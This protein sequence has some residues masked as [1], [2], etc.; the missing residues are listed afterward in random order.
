MGYLLIKFI[1][2]YQGMSVETVS[3][4][5]EFDIF[6]H[7]PIQTSVLETIETIYKPIFPVDQSD[8][9]FLIPADN[10][11]YLEINI[12]LYVRGKL[13]SGEGKDLDA[14]VFTVVIKNFLHSLFS[15]CSVTLNAVLI[16]QANELY[17]YRSYL[18]TLLTYVTDAAASHLTNS[19]WYL[20]SSDKLTCDST[21]AQN[22]TTNRGFIARWNKIKQRKKVQLYGRLHSTVLKCRCVSFS[23]SD[24]R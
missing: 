12:K 22:D 6:T 2:H 20:E 23:V 11:T 14:I 10:D 13:I 16:A 5:S 1:S 7:K 17:H 8:L 3:V 21:A 9:E 24:Y 18:K 15:Q 4:S 19:L